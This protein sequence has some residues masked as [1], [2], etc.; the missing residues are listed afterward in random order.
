[1][2]ILFNFECCAIHLI[3]IKFGLVVLQI[4]KGCYEVTVHLL[5]RLPCLQGFV[6][7]YKKMEL[8]VYIP[9]H[10]RYA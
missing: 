5:G 1:M 10:E 9:E 3:A 2:R 8:F 6:Q 7:Q 4:L